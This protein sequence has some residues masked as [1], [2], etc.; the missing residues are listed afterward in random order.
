MATKYGIQCG[1]SS[2]NSSVGCRRLSPITRK[3]P[4]PDIASLAQTI[5]ADRELV[6]KFDAFRK[7]RN[8]SQYDRAGQVTEKEV[9]EMK[10]LALVLKQKVT[11][12]LKITYPTLLPDK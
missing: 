12:W 3:P 9:K 5:G 6:D 11:T 8:I 10:K 1:S 7:K 2:G 4:F